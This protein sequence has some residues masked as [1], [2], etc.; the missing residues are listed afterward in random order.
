M[1]KGEEVLV[2]T[3]QKVLKDPFL[4]KKKTITFF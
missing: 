4:T 2:K 1:I 3:E